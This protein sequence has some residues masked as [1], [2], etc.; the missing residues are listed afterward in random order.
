MASH[1]ISQFENWPNAAVPQGFPD[2]AQLAVAADLL[3]P[4]A[5]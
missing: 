4:T 3:G 5:H 2:T 1:G